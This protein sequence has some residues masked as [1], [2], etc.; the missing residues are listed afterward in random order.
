MF[1]SG[2]CRT[3]CSDGR[4]AAMSWMHEVR[5]LVPGPLFTCGAFDDLY[6]LH[7]DGYAMEW[8]FCGAPEKPG[9]MA[10]SIALKQCSYM[11]CPCQ[12]H[13]CLSVP[14]ARKPR[15]FSAVHAGR[16]LHKCVASA[17]RPQRKSTKKYVHLCNAFPASLDVKRLY[18]HVAAE[19]KPYRESLPDQLN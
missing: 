10:C 11:N 13:L 8:Q 14:G 17:K 12:F 9:E 7:C 18:K 3:G 6:R 2:V 19:F 16:A 15:G 4:V 5:L 1:R